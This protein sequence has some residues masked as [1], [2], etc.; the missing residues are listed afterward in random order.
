M[1]KKLELLIPTVV[2]AAASG[3]CQANPPAAPRLE[4]E[5]ASIKP[6][7]PGADGGGIKPMASGQGYIVEG[8][9]VRLMILL[10]YHLNRNQLSGG[11]SWLDNE[12]YDI[13]AKADGPHTVD[14]LHTMFKNL[15]ADRF[16]L[17]FHMDK[18]VLPAYALIVDRS[19]PKVKENPSA[20]TFDVPIRAVGR[21]GRLDIAAT[22]SSMSYFVWFLSQFLEQPVVDLTGLSK[23]Y[24]FTLEWTPPEPPP[25]LGAAGGGDAGLPLANGPDLFTAVREQLGLKLESRKLPVDV[26]VIDHIERPSEN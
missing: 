10:M 20:E 24:D 14:E 3:L 2:C 1:I 12:L 9:P 15:L 18:K 16:K 4:F 26:M 19:G 13:E 11:P 25:G 5:V 8:A 21:Q 7:K 17:Q 23:F 6:S 22:H